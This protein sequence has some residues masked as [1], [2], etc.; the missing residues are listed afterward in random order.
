MGAFKN[1]VGVKRNRLTVD[2]F[3]GTKDGKSMWSCTCDCGTSGHIVQGYNLTSGHVKSCGCHRREVMS[4][5][6]SRHNPTH[7]QSGS[8]TYFSWQSMIQRCN[9]VNHIYFG[10]YGGRG[11]RVCGRW[12]GEGGFINFLADMGP[13]P[14]AKHSIDRF[15]DN[16]GDY[17]PGNCRWATGGQQNRN[18][19]NNRFIEAFGERRLMCEWSELSGIRASCIWQRLKRG[20]A[21]EAAL[22]MPDDKGNRLYR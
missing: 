20:M 22:S 6:A 18:R 3:A 1:L 12:Q 19:R 11:V 5:V 9:N 4:A 15:P 14:S 10:N 13:R 21:P 8:P 17:E 16:D 7:Q 2:A